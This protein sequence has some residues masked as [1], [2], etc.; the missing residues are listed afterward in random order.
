MAK[1]K[2]VLRC[3]HCGIILQ[4]EDPKAIGYIEKR[5]VNEHLKTN[6]EAILY[7]N[8]CY[9]KIKEMNTSTLKDNVDEDVL[10]ILDDAVAS[11]GVIIYVVDLFSF[12][13][14]FK[15]KI[16]KKI[17]NLNV[18]VVATKRDYFPATIKNEVFEQF[19][20]NY[21]NCFILFN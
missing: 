13:G 11:D 20:A 2:R 17:K 19:I 12:N 6:P 10:K 21:S 4:S 9:N 8:N 14:T 18:F 16:I 1:I 7:C 15:E 5:T 3:H